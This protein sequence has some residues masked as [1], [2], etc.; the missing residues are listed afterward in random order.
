MQDKKVVRER[1]IQ[2]LEEWKT[3]STNRPGR[4]SS[5]SGRW[6]QLNPERGADLFYDAIKSV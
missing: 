2:M 1:A 3:A 4:V 5:N 6:E